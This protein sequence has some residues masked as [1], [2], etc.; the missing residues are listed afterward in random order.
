MD[1]AKAKKTPPLSNLSMSRSATQNHFSSSMLV[2]FFVIV[3]SELAMRC[4][5]HHQA[6]YFSFANTQNPSHLFR[7][8]H[9]RWINPF[10]PAAAP[11]MRVECFGSSALRLA[12][13]QSVRHIGRE[14][15]MLFST[16]CNLVWTL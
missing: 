5:K 15:S 9:L 7:H 14:V 11:D 4:I 16:D 3:V 8:V 13:E 12:R 10:A 6:S 2:L 1:E